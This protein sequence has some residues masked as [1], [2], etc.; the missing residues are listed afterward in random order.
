MLQMS[1]EYAEILL[2][3]A[4]LFVP[5]GL[6]GLLVELRSRQGSARGCRDRSD[7]RNW[8]IMNSAAN[9]NDQVT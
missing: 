7:A 9:R 4:A 6:A 5:L 3:L 8:G 2:A 1:A